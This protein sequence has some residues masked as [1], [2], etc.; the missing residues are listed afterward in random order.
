[1]YLANKALHQA[2]YYLALIGG[3]VM[4][5]LSL[6]GLLGLRYALPFGSLLPGMMFGLGLLVPLILGIIAIVGA[7]HASEL[8]WAIVLII[9]GVVGG[10]I[11]GLLVL[12]GGVLG[13]ISKFA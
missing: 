9:I 11:G 8:V 3:I 4:V 2:A 6:L 13:L 10:G 5:L 12:L 1:M 7:K